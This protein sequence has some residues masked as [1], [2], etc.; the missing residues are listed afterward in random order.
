MKSVEIIGVASR[1]GARNAHSELGPNTLHQSSFAAEVERE[2]GIHLHWRSTLYPP[3]IGAIFDNATTQQ[4]L[5]HLCK[6]LSNHTEKLTQEHTPFVV[7]G[8]DHSCAMGTWAGAM[9]AFADTEKFGLIWIDA[10]LDAHTFATSPSGNIH[11]MPVAALLGA[12][13]ES[14]QKLC[15]AKNSL[16]ANNL[17]MLGI[18]S[19]EPEERD[20][21][22]KLKVNNFSN[23][24][25]NKQPSFPVLFKH[26]VDYASKQWDHFGI[27]ID[28]DGLDPEDAPAVATPVS[29]GILASDLCAA[30]RLINNCEK[31]TGIE[32]AEYE[33]T[34]DR[35]SKTQ[36]VIRNI[37][38]AVYGENG[39]H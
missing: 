3:D 24:D 25:L 28:L 9:N 23:D 37:I 21:L 26:L 2:F 34:N 39:N 31:L 6:T 32:I 35:A 1:L 29:G 11:G 38:G 18:R 7:I 14:L 8:G 20:L 17:L 4:S 15:P 22:L 13:D 36:R 33:P 27:S 30:L 5:T 16:K 10:H 19:F 12:G